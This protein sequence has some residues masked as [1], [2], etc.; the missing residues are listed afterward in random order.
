MSGQRPQ[1][2]DGDAAAVGTAAESCG[3]SFVITQGSEPWVDE[4]KK[5]ACVLLVEDDDEMRGLLASVLRADGYETVEAASG[6]EGVNYVYDSWGVG[7]R[8]ARPLDLIV[9][10]IRMPGW[11]G[12]DLLDVVRRARMTTPVL[13]I[14]AFG[15]RETHQ[16]AARLGAGAVLDKPFDLDEFRATVAA[17][18]VPRPPGG[19]GL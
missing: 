2:E 6:R 14:T 7:G 11:T 16:E 17:L 12:L 19:C 15:A 5:K 3:W 10:D 13:L 18:V 4:T 1:E 9:S 8:H